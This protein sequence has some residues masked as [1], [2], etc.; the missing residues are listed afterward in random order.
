ME[1]FWR[2]VGTWSDAHRRLAAAILVAVTV[3]L[4]IGLGNVDFATGQD[5]YLNPDSQV[6]IDNVAIQDRFGGENV[7]VLFTA[8]DGQPITQLFE[9]ENLAKLQ[10]M[11]DELATIPQVS[12]VITPLAA[13]E[14]TSG[15]IDGGAGSGA[16]TRAVARDPEP[17]GQQARQADVTVALARL[18]AA[19]NHTIG[20][21]SW[22]DLLLFG[23]DGYTVDASGAPVA[24]PIENRVIR[25]SLQSTFPAPGVAVGGIVLL[26]NAS[27]DE[28]SAGTEAVL[29]AFEGFQ[30]DGFDV[31][32]TGSPVYLKEINDYLKS[33]MAKLG[34][35]AVVVMIVV[36]TVLFKVRRR[37]L[38]LLAVL[39]GVLWAFSLLGWVGID[40]SLVT[41]SGLP[42][43]IGLGIDF[44]IQVH[45]RVEEEVQLDHD[46]H[47]LAE[48][49]ANM[50]PPIMVAAITGVVAFLALRI[51]KV[52]MIRDFGVL[53]AIGIVALAVI[54]LIIPI[55]TLGTARPSGER[56]GRS[57]SMLERAAVWLGSLPSKLAV[58]LA[59]ASAALFLAGVLVE[60]RTKIESDPIRWISQDS[61]VVKDVRTLEERTG[62]STTLGILVESNNV[63]DPAVIQVIHDFTRDAEQRPEV[64]ATS[65]LMNTMWKVITIPGAT[66]LPPTS[67]DL[68]AAAEVMPPAIRTALLSDDLTATQVNLRLAPASLDDRAVLVAELRADL[69]ARI[70]AIQLPPDSVLNV[71][72]DQG[73]PPM[74]AVPA[75]LATVGIGLLENLEANRATLTYLALAAAGLWLVLRLRSLTRA[76]LALVPVLLAIGVSSLIVGLAGMELSPLTT[77]SGPLVIAVVAE[78]SVLLL[79][80]YVEE[81]QRGLEPREAHDRATA[82]TGRA[83]LTSA[84]T[85][86]GGFAV[87]VASSLPLLRDFGIIVTLNV[88]I[89]L[90]AALVVV[91]PLL[92]WADQRG[93]LEAGEQP[94]SVRLGARPKGSHAAI[95]A[96]AGAA[97]IVATGAILLTADT[98]SGSAEEIA[99]AAAALPT[100]TTTTTTLPPTTPPPPGESVPAG[101]AIDPSGFPT[102]RPTGAIAG[103]LFDRLTEQGV[104]PNVA[105]C[106]VD[107]LFSRYDEPT[108]LGLGIATLEPAA[109]EPAYQAALDC[110]IPRPTI[111]AA[112][113]AQRTGS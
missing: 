89:A 27:L 75:G 20:D 38:P 112:I 36:L 17:A 58:P 79:G 109:L 97:L 93:W 55:L 77:V 56:G 63:L 71:A 90:G 101:P 99:Y 44:A 57:S 62:F 6:A 80:R 83:F 30:L 102:D 50:G 34:L 68:V 41:I 106:A 33:G 7:I 103:I 87:L 107:T 88:L 73:E 78:F 92:T 65:S 70:A 40:L 8:Q 24:P 13:L 26:G 113:E 60:G 19:P 104:A 72:V 59:L 12:S 52:P 48:T 4:G 61:Q 1:Q 42:I 108:L 21:S 53:L 98:S 3:V 29:K 110:G 37:L 95:A 96:I 82:R 18:S 49:A 94:G 9:G 91:P 74:R 45:N 10:A 51:S 2:S 39:F 15:I 11:N 69:D 28:Q 22:N 105:R 31:T 111:D 100:T 23:N 86:I 16:L 84:A 5:S 64:A 76:V 43:L 47:P 35:A 32:V 54:G 66:D 46:E 85:T 81:R 25:L 67:A 14:W